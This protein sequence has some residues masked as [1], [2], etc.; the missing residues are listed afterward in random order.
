MEYNKFES[1]ERLQRDFAFKP[2]PYKHYESVFTRFYQGY[3]L[4]EKF[5]VD[6]RKIHLSALIVSGQ[7]TREKAL[8]SLEGIPY[9]S[10]EELTQDKSYFLKKMGWNEA[11]LVDYLRRPGKAHDSYAS[12]KW[13]YTLCA[14][15]YKMLKR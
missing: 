11:Q 12:E 13:L 4:P 14:K 7:M 9:P 6:K 10:A 1:M 15:I 2:Y 8:K 3:I 5:G